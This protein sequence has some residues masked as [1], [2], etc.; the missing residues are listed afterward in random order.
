MCLQSRSSPKYRC[1]WP[2]PYARIV[3]PLLVQN[4]STSPYSFLFFA[5]AVFSSKDGELTDGR[6]A[7]S[8]FCPRPRQK[9][10]FWN[11]DYAEDFS[12][13][14]DCGATQQNWKAGLAQTGLEGSSAGGEEALTDFEAYFQA[15]GMQ[16]LCL[17][18]EGAVQLD[19]EQR[20]VVKL[21]R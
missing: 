4:V 8:G 11:R 6:I 9:Q 17:Q 21:S 15:A 10:M 1:I 16:W 14:K 2:G 7:A 20:V 12:R 13:K 3:F 5:E 18:Q 19:G